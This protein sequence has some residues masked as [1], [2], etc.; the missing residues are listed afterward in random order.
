MRQAAAGRDLGQEFG[1][2]AARLEKGERP[3]AIEGSLRKR[4]GQKAGPH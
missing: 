4:R 1:E 3:Q 2:V